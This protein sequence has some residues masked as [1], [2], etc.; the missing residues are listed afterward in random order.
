MQTFVLLLGAFGLVGSIIFAAFTPVTPASGHYNKVYLSWGFGL[1]TT[2]SCFFITFASVIAYFRRRG[3]DVLNYAVSSAMHYQAS[4]GAA[5]PQG[6]NGMDVAPPTYSEVMSQ[7]IAQPGGGQ[8]ALGPGTHPQSP[9]EYNSYK[10]SCPPDSQPP[11]AYYP[12]PPEG[13]FSAPPGYTFFPA[14]SLPPPV[15]GNCAGQT[16]EDGSLAVLP[17]VMNSG[18][19]LENPVATFVDFGANTTSAAAAAAPVESEPTPVPS[20]TEA[21]FSGTPVVSS[22]PVY[23]VTV[24]GQ[25]VPVFQEEL[26]QAGQEVLLSA[27]PIPAYFI[28]T[29]GHHVPVYTEEQARA[30]AD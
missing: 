11:P 28:M 9:S 5:V 2:S 17:P 23:Y 18:D 20:R 13:Q 6:F 21:A 25:M 29:Q 8:G 3:L 16:S 30:L 24:Q 14:S 27:A 26:Q 19:G 1:S 22:V 15:Q 12:P 10:T 4:D 7:P